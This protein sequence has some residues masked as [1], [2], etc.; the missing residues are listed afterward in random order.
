MQAPAPAPRTIRFASFEVDLRAGEVRKNGSL[1]KVQEL[2][3]RA[4]VL[5]LEHPGELVTRAEFRE[6]LWPPDI[7]VDFDR[8]ISSTISRLRDSLGDSAE[9]SRFIQTVGRRGYRFIAPITGP[10]PSVSAPSASAPSKGVDLPKPAPR[11]I[12]V[13]RWLVPTGIAALM[14][15][16]TGIALR[17]R[18]SPAQAPIRSLAVLPLE[19]LTGNPENEYLSDGMTDELITD[20]AKVGGPRV[21]SRTSVMR[22]KGTRKSLP[23][24]ARELDVDA[25]IEGTVQALNGRIHVRVQLVQGRPERHLWAESYDSPAEDAVAVQSELAR[26]IAGAIHISLSPQQQ[27]RLERK[28]SPE[29]YQLYLNGRYFWNKRTESTLEKSLEYFQQAVRE[30]PDYA[31]AYAGLA[32]SYTMLAAGEYAVLPSAEAVPRAKAAA[33][34]ALQLDDTLAE[35]HA[36]LGFLKWSFEWDWQGAES[37]YKKAIA[38]TPSYATAH[39][40]Y[41]LYLVEIGRFGDAVVEIRK[42]EELDPFS[43]IVRTDVGWILYNARR[44]DEA[45]QQLAKTLDLDPHFASAH[46]TLGLAYDAKRMSQEAI[47]EFQKS[48]DLSGGRPVC[49]AAL[50]HAYAVAGMRDKALRILDG[51]ESQAKYR[52]VLPDGPAYIYAA[53]GDHD[54][55]LKWLEQAYVQH[56]DVMTLLKVEP[57]LDPLRS[58]PRFLEL[59]RRI[60]FPS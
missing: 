19:N 12:G 16:A 20:L 51:L 24:I 31:L 15:L 27:A 7:F 29:A 25:I 49:L 21:I 5:L 1:I 56:T 55:A 39:H 38:L 60:N 18:I 3:F 47:A 44:Y 46:W 37:E 2:P 30:N 57:R 40:W 34:K 32:D 9:N 17:N 48:V 33:E 35:A 42:A 36:T 11:R 10:A 53:L 14:L 6:A 41:A 52:Y 58:D 59:V 4:L 23:E 50:G 45:I 8:G 13:T 26:E 22:Y 54:R 43:V 28:V